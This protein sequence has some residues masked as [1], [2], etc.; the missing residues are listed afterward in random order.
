MIYHPVLSSI[1]LCIEILAAIVAILNYK[2]VSQTPWKWLVVY[3]SVIAFQET[4]FFFNDSLVSISKQDYYAYFGIPIQYL[5][6]F[7]LYA[8]VSLKKKNLF[9]FFSFL[10]LLVYYPSN[11]FLSGIHIVNSINISLGNVLILI[12][13]IM[14]FIKQIKDDSIIKFYENRMFYINIG[15]I[16]L[17]IGCFP[18]FAFYDILAKKENLWLW[19]AYYIF[20]LIANC[21]LYML[22][23]ISFLWGK[24]KN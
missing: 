11:T 10:Y 15:M 17:Y 2:K 23:T 22:Y 24:N 8:F 20:F 14:E 18:F 6:L 16:L 9:Y 7:W 3:L 1:L 13:V 21:S 5:F 19:N 12:V 4:Y